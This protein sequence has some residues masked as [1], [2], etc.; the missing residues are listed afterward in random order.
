MQT[1]D[2]EGRVGVDRVAAAGVDL[3]VE[4]GAGH[5]AG[6]ADVPDHL[7]GLHG[8]ADGG[9]ELVLVAVPELGA[10]GQGLDRPVAVG[11]GVARLGDRAAGDRHDR[12]AGGGGAV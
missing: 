4:V 7:A 2:L 11:A 10:V 12:R 3:E 1:V 9:A 8:G 6:G 5:V